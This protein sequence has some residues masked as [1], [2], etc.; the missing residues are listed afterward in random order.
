MI[1]RNNYDLF[2]PF[3]VSRPAP[4]AI[5]IE[6]S[7]EDK[8]TLKKLALAQLSSLQ[9]FLESSE[10]SE[11]CIPRTKG[12]RF[13]YSRNSLEVFCLHV[14]EENWKLRVIFVQIKFL[15]KE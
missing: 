2:Y 3:L 4:F 13:F 14:N 6:R 12:I 7:P 9:V 5:S 1:F 15:Q 11:C 10:A 8:S